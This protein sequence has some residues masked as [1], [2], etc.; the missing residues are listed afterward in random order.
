MGIGTILNQKGLIDDAQLSEAIE[1]QKRTGERLD[2]VLV[3]LG[4]IDVAEVLKAIGTHFEMPI[5]DLETLEVDEDTLRTL[6]PKLIFKQ[7]CVPIDRSNGVLRVATSDPFEL[8]AFDELR[9]LTGMGIELVLADERDLTKFIR[10]HYGV[11][12]DTLEALAT[13]DV[14]EVAPLTDGDADEVEMAQEA[15]VIKLVND[16]LLEAIRERATD[17]HIEPFEEDLEIRYRVDGVLNKAG[18]PQSVARFRNAIVSRLKIMANLNI[19]EKRMPQD[20]RITMRSRGREYDLRVSIIPMLHGEGVVLRVLDQGSVML[21]LDQ[22]GMPGTVLQR[23]DDLI[24][25]PHGILLVTGPTGSGKSTTLYAS[26][27]RI[28]SDELKAITVE[29]P[30]EY[31][32]PRVN[33]IP[34]NNAIGFGFAQGL[35]AILRH[36]PDIIMIGEIRDRETADASVQASLTGH[37]VFSTLHT[38]DAGSAPTRLLDM[39]VEPYLV[40]SAV[41]GVLAQRLLRRVCTAC[42]RPT[43]ITPEEAPTGLILP[44]SRHV[45]EAEGC[46]EC[47]RT[48]YQGR[49]G[50]YEL[51]QFNDTTRELVMEQAAAG[52]IVSEAVASGTINLLRDEALTLVTDHVTTIQEAM[53][54]SRG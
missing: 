42:A 31:Q 51:L 47:R 44:E 50:I 3:R 33:Q 38:N 9:L 41:E 20:G 14:H 25:R 17:V 32:V 1:E 21:G 8:S 2:R 26:L 22:L 4:F 43:R 36:D 45:L 53:R 30:V 10:A 46:R 16:L 54:V 40:S 13:S 6:P 48:G 12:G 18:V 5:V 24:S 29:D 49:V 15:S 7:R 52:R 28:V 39:G 11:A 34:V 37:L 35:R 27:N 23:W 19:A